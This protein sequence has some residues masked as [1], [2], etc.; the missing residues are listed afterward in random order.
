MP[1]AFG[2]PCWRRC[3]PC[4]PPGWARAAAAT[5]DRDALVA[6]YLAADGPTWDRA[7]NWLSDEP[8]GEWYGVTADDSGR[9]TELSLP[10][11]DLRGAIPAELGRLGSLEVMDLA[12]N[13]LSGEFPAGSGNFANLRVLSLGGNALSGCIPDAWGDRRGDDVF[14]LDMPISSMRAI[15]LPFCGSPG[16]EDRDVL[17][18]FYLATD[19]SNWENADNWLSGEPIGDW[20]GVATNDGG[21]ITGLE[22]PGNN[23]G[24]R[25]PAIL[26]RL[27]DLEVLDIA[28][29]RLRGE[30]PPELAS[31]P[32]LTEL[33]LQDNRLS[34]C[35]PDAFGI[36][37]DSDSFDIGLPFCSTLIP[38][39]RSVLVTLFVST[40]GPNW[41][42]ADNWMTDA[43]I[44]E[45]HG[46]TVDSDGL[47][48]ELKLS[49]NGLR[50][51]F[52]RSWPTSRA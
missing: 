10:D 5:T 39:E 47:V 29:N 43:P 11:N 14:D 27:A 2:W 36:L 12:D 46:V 41:V 16:R 32:N 42:R 26:V 44:G 3:A 51:R 49:W 18:A 28:D 7:D 20:Y 25:I 21:R 50:G 31:L 1:T 23:L 35:I 6:L 22:L 52:R 37:Q 33:Y 45:W 15:G 40:G 8:V 13:R 34:G 24:A 17:V 48:T 9:V 4:W 38:G 30:I 19:G